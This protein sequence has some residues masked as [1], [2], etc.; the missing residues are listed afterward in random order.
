MLGAAFDVVPE[1]S[2]L[3]SDDVCV[4]SGAGTGLRTG[5]RALSNTC[6]PC[7]GEHQRSAATSR[8][9]ENAHAHLA[10]H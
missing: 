8:Y 10:V 2:R 5:I 1:V 4:F 7:S 6:I 9:V 3:D